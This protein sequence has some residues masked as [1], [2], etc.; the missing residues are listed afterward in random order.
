M[1]KVVPNNISFINGMSRHWSLG[2]RRYTD[3]GH[4]ALDL[5]VGFKLLGRTFTTRKLFG[6]HTGNEIKHLSHAC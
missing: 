3:A 6:K 4:S 5:S 2:F 1:S